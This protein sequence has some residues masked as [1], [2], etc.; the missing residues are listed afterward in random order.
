[1]RN[2]APV[3]DRR[4]PTSGRDI[5]HLTTATTTYREMDMRFWLEAAEVETRELK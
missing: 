3:D 2:E 5:E 1:M 4:W